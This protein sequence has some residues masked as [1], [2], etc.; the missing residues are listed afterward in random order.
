MLKW[1]ITTTKRDAWSSVSRGHREEPAAHADVRDVEPDVTAPSPEVSVLTDADDRLVWR[2]FATL[3][4]RCKALLRAIAFADRPDYASVAQ[5]LGMPVGSIGPTRGRCL[6]K[7]RA[8]TRRRPPL[9]D[10]VMNA[11]RA[12]DDPR[13]R[14]ARRRGPH[15]LDVLRH[16]HQDV[17]PVPEDLV[18]RV[19]FAMTVAAPGG[20]GRRDRLERDAR[21][22]ARH[23]LR[24]RR[25]RDLR[26]RRAQRHGDHRAGAT[27][28]V[29]IVGWVSETGAVE[30]ELR[31]RGRTRTTVVDDEG[32]FTFAGV[33]RGLV[34]FVLRRGSDSGMPPIIT[35]AIEL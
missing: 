27:T 7:L 25:H 2:H 30:V 31:E 21:D 11:P 28:K 3:P 8:R 16:I 18:D 12:R 1:L 23:R 35:P 4:E 19:K 32:R 9:G 22:R 15:L 26:E 24:P 29:D 20:R 13:R 6:A 33:E 14:A 17:D 34:S 5:A 10:D